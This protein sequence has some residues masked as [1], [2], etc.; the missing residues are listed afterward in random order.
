MSEVYILYEHGGDI[1]YS[2]RKVL[3]VYSNVKLAESAK[4]ILTKRLHSYLDSLPEYPTDDLMESDTDEWSKMLDAH[5][6]SV[7]LE[8]SNI[9]G[10]EVVKYELNKP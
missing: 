4:E 7:S 5:Y 10:Y 2:Y 8:F 3:G 6:E 9:E 1:E